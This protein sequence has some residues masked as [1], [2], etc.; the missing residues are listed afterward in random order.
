MNKKSTKPVTNTRI[1][2][3]T[4]QKGGVGKTA[5]VFNLAIC[6][7]KLKKRVLIVDMDP[8]YNLSFSIGVEY[9]EDKFTG[10]NIEDPLSWDSQDVDADTLSTYDLIIDEIPADKVIQ[11]VNGVD[12]IASHPELAVGE[13]E[14]VSIT[15]RET[16][17]RT[18]LEPIL[19]RYDYIL[20][21]CP[22]NLGYLTINAITAA[23]DVIIPVQTEMYALLGLRQLLKT[24]SKTTRKLNPSLNLMGLL[25]TMTT[26]TTISQDAIEFMRSR[27]K[28]KMFKTTI[29][30]NIAIAKSPAEKQSV[31]DFDKR[32]HGAEDYLQLAK[33]I[34]RK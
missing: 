18:A 33:E 2:A 10:I 16:Q 5:T 19:D 15:A 20:L 27:F 12:I 28:T 17:L 29:R 25:A 8:Q 6:L 22:P 31:V 26:N 13:I 11:S 21:D 7:Q 1:I 3:F 24:I 34:V 23:T 32:S 14:L 4:N 9:P 30:R